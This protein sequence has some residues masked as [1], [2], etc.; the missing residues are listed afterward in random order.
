MRFRVLVR[1]SDGRCGY[2]MSYTHPYIPILLPTRNRAFISLSSFYVFGNAEII[3]YDTS[4][5]LEKGEEEVCTVVDLFGL[6]E[7]NDDVD[8]AG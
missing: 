5:H 2:D 6:G 7:R 4:I 8:E 3:A 1:V